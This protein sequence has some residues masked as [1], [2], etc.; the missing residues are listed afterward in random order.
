MIVSMVLVWIFCW[1][2]VGEVAAL[3]NVG[4]K[5]D[6][7]EGN[8]IVNISGRHAPRS[9]I[10]VTYGDEVIAGGIDKGTG[11]FGFSFRISGGQESDLW[12]FAIDPA[13]TT[14]RLSLDSGG[15]IGVLMPPTLVIDPAVSTLD[16]EVGVGGY[17]Y[18]GARVKV[19]LS[20]DSLL[21]EEREFITED[22]GGYEWIYQELPPGEY[23]AV[24]VSEFGGT[25]S[26]PSQELRFRVDPGTAVS[27]IT[28]TAEGVGQRVADT[29]E[30]IAQ[31]LLPPVVGEAVRKLAPQ[32]SQVGTRVAPA[33]GVGLL[34]QLTLISK[35]VMLLLFQSATAGLQYFG[36]WRKRYPWGVVYD[37]VTKQPIML[38][39]V[40]LYS[41]QQMKKLAETD[42]TSKVGVFSFFPKAGK[43]VVMA[44]KSGYEFPSRLVRGATDG[45]YARVYH[46]EQIEFDQDRGV[47]EVSIPMDPKEAK[48]D[49]KF[50]VMTF[51]RRRLHWFSRVMLIVGWVL[52]LV[53]VVGGEGEI[54]GLFLLLYTGLLGV[55]LWLIYRARKTWG[56]VVD[57]SGNSL[58]GVQLDLIDPAFEKLVQRRISDSA[59]KYQFIVPE[60]K[61]EIRISS[62]NHK[63]VISEPKAYQG[64]AIVVEGNKPRLIALK[65][66]V[67]EIKNDVVS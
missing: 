43:Y 48:V 57:R 26:Q 24:A 1:Q 31:T 18:P 41:L 51:L 34:S 36:F 21:V 19:T 10:V 63:L 4:A 56:I 66:V 67:E 9:Q 23:V 22:D 45:E 46:G 30:N 64:Q 6:A 33:V 50:K 28:R 2:V 17:S 37:A 53:A 61:Y 54:H 16:D 11:N 7:V 49:W 32:A 25:Q 38:A 55:Q 39:T 35:D 29:V 20:R 65:I 13:G 14:Q 58:E 42:V 62:I 52:A 15:A 8:I 40:R 5:V 12:L 27:P 44:T 59:G 3:E 47:V 60:G